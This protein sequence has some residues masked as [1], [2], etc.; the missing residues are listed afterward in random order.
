MFCLTPSSP[1]AK[2]SAERPTTG[3]EAVA[4]GSVTVGFLTGVSRPRC[5]A[6]LGCLKR[7]GRGVHGRPN[8]RK[9][10]PSLRIVRGDGGESQAGRDAAAWKQAGTFLPQRRD[11]EQAA[12]NARTRRCP[13]LRT[14]SSRSDAPSPRP[15]VS[16]RGRRVP[17]LRMSE[18]RGEWKTRFAAV[19][20]PPSLPLDVTSGTEF[21]THRVNR[22]R[23]IREDTRNQTQG[24][25]VVRAHL[26]L[27]RGACVP[28]VES[29]R[30]PT[31]PR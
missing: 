7:A 4:Q 14:C 31:R 10:M 6:D 9:G 19:G 11:G 23:Q 8:V 29:R 2:S 28:R 18:N 26:T 5:V 15:K 21:K 17:V 3:P 12:V 22:D 1:R 30:R 27:V 25:T 16:R 13:V 20:S 24:E